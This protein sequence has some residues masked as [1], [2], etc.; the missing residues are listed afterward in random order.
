M[1]PI[2]L[3]GIKTMSRAQALNYLATW[4]RWELSAL[5]K[6]M[7][8]PTKGERSTLIQRIVAE[9]HPAQAKAEP[10]PAACQESLL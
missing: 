3:E 1:T 6:L 5:A 2:E 8:Q 4:E 7:K 9:T 10:P